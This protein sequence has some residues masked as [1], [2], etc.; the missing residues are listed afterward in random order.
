MSHR[1]DRVRSEGKFR[2]ENGL[3]LKTGSLSHEKVV[4]ITRDR[5]FVNV[6]D[7][8]TQVEGHGTVGPSVFF[9]F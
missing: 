1:I 2:L 3:P 7:L 5:V 9:F 8:L 6:E 4:E